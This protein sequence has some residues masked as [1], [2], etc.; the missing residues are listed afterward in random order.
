[1]TGTTV[2]RVGSS[3]LGFVHLDNLAHT[4]KIEHDPKTKCVGHHLI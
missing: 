4:K 3:N 1:M 2:F